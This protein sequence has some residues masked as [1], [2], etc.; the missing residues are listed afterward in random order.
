MAEHGSEERAN[1][2]GRDEVAAVDGGGG[3]AGEEE[4][5]RGA[6]A[7]A[8]QDLLADARLADEIDDVGDEFVLDEDLAQGAAQGGDLVRR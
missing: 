1:V 8:D 4:R 2:V 3:A 6:R 7:G 5:L